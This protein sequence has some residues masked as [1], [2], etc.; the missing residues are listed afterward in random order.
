MVFGS[1][2]TRRTGLWRALP[3]V[4]AILPATALAQSPGRPDP[5]ARCIALAAAYY[6]SPGDPVTVQGMADLVTAVM[7]SEGTCGRTHT[8][9]DGSVD[10]GCMGI[11]TRRLAELAPYRITAQ[12]LVADDCLNIYVGTWMLKRELVN[13]PNLWKAI[14]NYNSHTPR[15]NQRYQR[16]VWGHLKRLWSARSSDR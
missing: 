13:E 2:E 11:N 14:G 3:L 16:L 6:H 9:T 8:N 7:G 15:W 10:Y 12:K 4:L 1:V 5:H